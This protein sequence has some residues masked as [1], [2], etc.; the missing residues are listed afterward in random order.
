[1]EVS[2]A[3][4][5][6]KELVIDLVRAVRREDGEEKRGSAERVGE[7]VMRK[8]MANDGRGVGR[9][10]GEVRGRERRRRC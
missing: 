10:R 7:E 8:V 2:V 6:K 4:G 9:T 1:M 3:K 5:R